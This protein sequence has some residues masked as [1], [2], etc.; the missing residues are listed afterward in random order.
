MAYCSSETLTDSC[1]LPRSQGNC[2]E[3]LPRWFFDI[4]ENRCMPFYYSGCEGNANN[5][6]TQAACETDC[7]SKVGKCMFSSTI[8]N[9][10]NMTKQIAVKIFELML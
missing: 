5:F 6:E 9:I 3:K 1:A 7:P 10:P 8:R 2:T 4:S